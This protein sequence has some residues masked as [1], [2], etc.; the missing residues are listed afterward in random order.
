MKKEGK[1]DCYI[2]E[3]EFLGNFSTSELV[4]RIIKDHIK[5][6]QDRLPEQEQ[7][8]GEEGDRR[9]SG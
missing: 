5:L 6:E 9:C 4:S 2:V 1:A 7:H 8:P 3:R